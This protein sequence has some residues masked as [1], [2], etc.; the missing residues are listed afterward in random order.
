MLLYSI[1]TSVQIKLGKLSDESRSSDGFPTG[2]HEPDPRTDQDSLI[3]PE[4]L[5]H[6]LEIDDLSDP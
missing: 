1:C 4:D 5:D 6:Q 2:Q 3:F